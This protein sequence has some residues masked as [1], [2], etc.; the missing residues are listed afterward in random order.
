MKL[1]EQ[2]KKAQQERKEVHKRW[3]KMA[4]EWIKLNAELAKAE[5]KVIELEKKWVKQAKAL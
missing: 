3:Q 5:E 2:I 4:V 1:E